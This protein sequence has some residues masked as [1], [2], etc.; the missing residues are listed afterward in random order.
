M[1]T[2]IN[3]FL[4]LEGELKLGI[5]VNSKLEGIFSHTLRLEK[6]FPNSSLKVFLSIKLSEVPSLSLSSTE[7]V[8]QNCSSPKYIEKKTYL[9]FAV[10]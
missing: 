8:I 5:S 2:R 1:D 7:E 4:Q 10:V 6:R 3:S 9:L